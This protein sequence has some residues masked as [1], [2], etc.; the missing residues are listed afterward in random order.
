[1]KWVY[2]L[3]FV[4]LGTSPAWAGTW[5]GTDDQI[6]DSINSAQMVFGTNADSNWGT[7]INMRCKVSGAT[8][9]QATLFKIKNDPHTVGYT[10]DSARF[11][12]FF[13][14][15]EPDGAN[16][17]I[18]V[19]GRVVKKD[20]GEGIHFGTTATTGECSWDSAKVGTI[21]WTTDGCLSNGNDRNATIACSLIVV[22]PASAGQEFTC[23]IEGS[24]LTSEFFSYGIVWHG[25]WANAGAGGANFDLRL[26][27]DD[28]ATAGHRPYLVGYET[29]PA[30]GQLSIGVT[31]F[32]VVTVGK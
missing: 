3:I 19:Y 2:F 16:D 24:H 32:G 4:L 31:S 28:H 14:N 27:S 8:N 26:R 23:K 18:V 30:G 11:H 21:D 7:S 12:A 20:W 25:G 10:Q 15:G 9:E 1:M 29:A 13:D 6:A 5:G 22:G 17:T